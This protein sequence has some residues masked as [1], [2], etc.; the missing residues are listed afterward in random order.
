MPTIAER[1]VKLGGMIVKYAG[2]AIANSA[3]TY[4]DVY[5]GNAEFN[6]EVDTDTDIQNWPSGELAEALLTELPDFPDTGN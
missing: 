3:T 4:Q 5:N 1:L 6:D 2:W